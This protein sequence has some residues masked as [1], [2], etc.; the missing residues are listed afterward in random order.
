MND[1]MSKLSMFENCG[2][3]FW[4]YER[5]E[6]CLLDVKLFQKQYDVD[7]FVHNSIYGGDEAM[8]LMPMES[9]LNS[10]RVIAFR[11]ESFL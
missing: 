10:S 5:F 8:N 7:H 11:N 2:R 1:K 4:K 6:M 9:S 3:V